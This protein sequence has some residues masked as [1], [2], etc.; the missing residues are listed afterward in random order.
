MFNSLGEGWLLN[1]FFL[2]FSNH[3]NYSIKNICVYSKSKIKKVTNKQNIEHFKMINWR[4]F[5]HKL[6]NNWKMLLPSSC[7]IFI[8]ALVF[9]FSPRA[10]F[11]FVEALVHFVSNSF[12]IHSHLVQKS[13][14]KK[15]IILSQRL[16][17]FNYALLFVLIQQITVTFFSYLIRNYNA[18]TLN[19]Q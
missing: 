3:E 7:A 1:C 17:S 9:S 4:L 11:F 13:L 2:S 5:S 6:F 8:R 12:S 15:T 14:N 18:M 19:M 16:W 10:N